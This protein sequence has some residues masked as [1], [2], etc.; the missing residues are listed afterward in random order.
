MGRSTSIE[1][2]DATW[3]PVSGCTRTSE[4]CLN[5]YIERSRP[6]LVARRKFDGPDIG[7]SLPVQLHPNRLDWPLT[8]REPLM[9]FVCSHADLFHKDVPDTFIAEIYARMALTRQSIFHVLTKRHDRMHAMLTS[10]DLSGTG[11]GLS[12]EAMVRNTVHNMRNSSGRADWPR[13]DDIEWPLPNVWQGVTAENQKWFDIRSAALSATPAAVRYISFEPMVGP[14][15]GGEHLK[16]FDWAI[17]GGESG[18]GPD[19]RPM[20]PEWARSLRDQCQGAGV[21]YFFKQWGEFVPED[22]PACIDENGHRFGRVGAVGYDGEPLDI[23][24]GNLLPT[25]AVRVRRIGKKRAGRELDG[26]I[27]HEFP[28]AS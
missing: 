20:H 2:A 13:A 24:L 3:S 23:R 1:T 25:N 8:W 18:P 10:R 14:I 26:R 27:W 12:L 15:D 28:A 6:M 16:E 4:G 21:A 11:R 22:H 19:V 17:V 7:A 9:I 5:C